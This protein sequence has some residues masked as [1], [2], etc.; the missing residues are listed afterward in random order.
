M[1]LA[2]DRDF[3]AKD[4]IYQDLAAT[5]ST[6]FYKGAVVGINSAT[7]LCRPFV[8]ASGDQFGGIST[9]KKLTV[10]GDKLTVR[11]EGIVRITGQSGFA[12]SAVGELV[13]ASADDTVT[14][15]AT[16]NLL[17]GRIVAFESASVIWIELAP[18]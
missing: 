5:A 16:S 1:A 4:G 2:A 18:V 8:T 14:L 6:Q 15:T 12:A 13:Y 11:R 17:I 9:E 7:G 3:Q 10:T